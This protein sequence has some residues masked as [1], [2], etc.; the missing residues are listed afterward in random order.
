[1]GN[2]GL[3]LKKLRED[4]GLT[5]KE[6]EKATGVNCLMIKYWEEGQRCLTVGL[7]IKLAKY[8]GVSIDYLVGI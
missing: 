3:R 2:F 1:M 6:L 4:K 5:I 7:L 8:F